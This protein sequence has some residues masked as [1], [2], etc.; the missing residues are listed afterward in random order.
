MAVIA[1]KDPSIAVHRLVRQAGDFIELTHH[2]AGLP[3]DGI[4]VDDR[5]VQKLTQLPCQ[6]RFS[7]TGAAD[8]H[9]PLYHLSSS[10]MQFP[11]K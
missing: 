8:D 5:K 9:D 3:I 6:R 7:R 2:P 11:L 1:F 4:D 10:L